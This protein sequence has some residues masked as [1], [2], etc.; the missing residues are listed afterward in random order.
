MLIPL[1][2]FMQMQPDVLIAQALKS[3]NPLK[4]AWWV[5]LLFSAAQAALDRG[6]AGIRTLVQIRNAKRFL[7]AYM[8]IGFRAE[9]GEQPT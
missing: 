9:Q 2:P 7:H 8:L 3:R 6:A 5:S 1:A 4:Q